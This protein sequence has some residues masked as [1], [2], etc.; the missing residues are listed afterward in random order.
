MEIFTFSTF[1]HVRCSSNLFAYNFFGAFNLNFI[2][3][4]EVS[5]KFCFFG[6][7]LDLKKIGHV[8]TL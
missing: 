6:N 1:T 4:F 8:S 3:G 5:K 7:L 2:S